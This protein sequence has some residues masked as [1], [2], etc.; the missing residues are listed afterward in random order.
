MYY[1]ISSKY[2]L[3]QE[4]Q[5][6]ERYLIAITNLCVIAGID[7]SRLI[8][9]ILCH[10]G[11]HNPESLFTVYQIDIVSYRLVHLMILPQTIH[12]ECLHHILSVDVDG[13]DGIDQVGIVKHHLARLLRELF[14]QGVDD[15][16]QT[17][18][19]QV[20]D[21]VHHRGTTGLNVISQL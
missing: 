3:I 2:L 1:Y 5:Q 19:C 20:F 17:G 11:I 7:R 6:P 16:D 21:V 9:D 10:Q 12:E 15:I 14:P 13:V 4:S 8:P 18:V